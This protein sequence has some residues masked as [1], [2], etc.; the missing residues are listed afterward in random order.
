MIPLFNVILILSL[1]SVNS[2]YTGLKSRQVCGHCAEN[3]HECRF[4]LHCVGKFPYKNS[5][6]KCMGVSTLNQDCRWN[7]CASNL[8]CD[9]SICKNKV[10]PVTKSENI[11]CLKDGE[12]CTRFKG[13]DS[14]KSSANTDNCCFPL[15]CQNGECVGESSKNRQCVTANCAEGLK[16]N[17]FYTCE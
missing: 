7:T 5:D 8:Y 16:C 11:T 9:G 12:S 13:C 6:Y 4:P 10:D 2:S 3:D 15:S 1:I 17:K 14:G